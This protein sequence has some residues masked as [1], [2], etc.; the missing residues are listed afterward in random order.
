MLGKKDVNVKISTIIGRGSECYGDFTSTGSIRMDGIVNGNLSVGGTVIIGATGVVNGNI[1]A[2]AAIIG[3]QVLGNV[4]APEKVE[5]IATA[6]VFGDV[7]T[8]V[9]VIDEKAIFQGRC[10]MNKEVPSAG[11]AKSGLKAVRAGRKTAKAAIVEALKAD[12]DEEEYNEI[13]QELL[14]Q[15]EEAVAVIE[16]QNPSEGE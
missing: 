10:N 5:M 12:A 7:T 1:S 11:K 6:Q 3:G 9:L 8:A 15:H 4:V 16:E 13:K 14:E 2:K